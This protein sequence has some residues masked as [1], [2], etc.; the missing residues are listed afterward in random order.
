M[1]VQ[2]TGKIVNV[3]SVYALVGE[4]NVLPYVVT[5]GALAQMTK[6]LAV[7]WARDNIQVNA[8]APG[9]VETDLNAQALEDDG[10]RT[11]ILRRTPARRLGSAAEVAEAVYFLVGPHSDYVTGHVLAVDGGWLAW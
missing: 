4:S 8:V 10:L 6:G 3:A 7:E 1:R 9:Y 11:R 5:K 2:A